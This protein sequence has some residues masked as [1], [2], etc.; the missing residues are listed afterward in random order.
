[1]KKNIFIIAAFILPSIASAATLSVSPSSQSISVGD[2]FSVTVNLDTQGAFI[3]GV[4]LRYLNYN[5]ALLEMQDSNVSSGIQIVPGS[6]MPATLAN[7]VDTALGRITFSQVT[8]GG[9]KYKGLGTLATITFKALAAGNARLTFNHNSNNTTDSNVASMGLDVLS[10]VV[11]GSYTI[12]NVS[13]ASGGGSSSSGGNSSGS[14]GS[15]AA[16]FTNLSHGASGSEVKILQNFLVS[17]GY[18]T[19]DNATGFFGNL[20]QT[21]TQSFQRAQNIVSS[22][23]PL[24]TGYGVVGPTTRARIN[25]LLGVVQTVQTVPT[26]VTVGG[27][28]NRNLSRGSGGS[29]VIALQQFLV[30]QGLLSSDNATGYFGPITETAIKAFQ[31]SQNIVSSGTPQ[32]TGYGNVGA[33]T[34]ARINA[35][36][37]VTTTSSI[38]N[39]QNLQAQIDAMQKQVQELLLKLQS[40][41]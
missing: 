39:I 15:T 4:D 6:L 19:A 22:G 16:I 12:N 28:L 40:M 3:D 36:L 1:M 27:S 25:S 35:L 2:I 29:D 20:T 41:Q 23:S 31:K 34:R 7:S 38:Q 11:N 17:Q 8:A 14:T 30:R 9:N 21:A 24:T 13:S 26:S 37:G 33:T 32:T 18:L 5:P 10:N